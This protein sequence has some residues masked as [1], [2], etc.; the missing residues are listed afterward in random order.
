MKRLTLLAAALGA[1][2]GGVCQTPYWQDVATVAVGRENPR[3][4]FVTFSSPEKAAER[5]FAA[6]DN[7]RLLNGTWKFKYYD[8]YGDVP[9]SATDPAEDSSSWDDIKVP[10][11]WELQGHGTAIYVNH[12]YEFQTHNPQP[13]ALPEANPVGVYRRE[14][15]IGPEW[16]DKDIFLNL[17]GAKS[18]VYV[19][20]NGREVG[21]SED[22][23]D[24]ASFRITD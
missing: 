11:N 8:A 21:Y 5:D 4:E 10:G 20:V 19:Y 6:S 1:S 18:G 22:S 13:P 23:K 15:T 16:A 24:L 2:L 17:A 7:Y 3:T 14:F 9:A 12:P